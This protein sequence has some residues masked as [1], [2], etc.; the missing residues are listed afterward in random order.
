[1]KQSRTLCLGLLLL[2][3]LLAAAALTFAAGAAEN[4]VYISDYGDNA[5]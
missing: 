1:M 4:V 3:A 2:C 5:H